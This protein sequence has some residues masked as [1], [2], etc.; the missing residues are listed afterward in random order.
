MQRVGELRQRVAAE[1][2]AG[3]AGDLRAVAIAAAEAA[4]LLREGYGRHEDPR[5]PGFA[6]LARDAEAWLLQVA[7]EARQDRADLAAAVFREGERRHCSRCHE[8]ARPLYRW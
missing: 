3:P 2:D 5:V 6:R 8:A 1:C 4:A 7:L